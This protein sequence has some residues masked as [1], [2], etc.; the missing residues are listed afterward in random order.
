M[1]MK[2]WL[3]RRQAIKE[4]C[5]SGGGNILRS[6]INILVILSGLR[7]LVVTIICSLRTLRC[8]KYDDEKRI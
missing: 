5:I 8:L 7:V 3:Q 6:Q 2:I 4:C 1:K